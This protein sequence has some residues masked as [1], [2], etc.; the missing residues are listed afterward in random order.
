M[1]PVIKAG[2]GQIKNP[3]PKFLKYIF[4]TYTFL[5]GLWAIF[6]PAITHLPAETIAEV[7]KWVLIGVPV[8][9]FTIKFF[10]LDYEMDETN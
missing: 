6:S 8:I 5:A 9:H 1:E 2:L 3:T 10:G 4:R 7:N